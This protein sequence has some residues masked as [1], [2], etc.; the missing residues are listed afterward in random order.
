[1]MP[2]ILLIAFVAAISHVAIVSANS[3][4]AGSCSAG[5]AAIGGTH[6]DF[7]PNSVSMRMGAI[8]TIFEA[9]SIVEINGI[10]LTADTPA[11]FPANTD[12]TWTVT[13]E[14][15][16]YKGIFVRVQA[17][18][19]NA[20]T[21]T[22]VG[23]NLKNEAFCDALTE[24]VIGVSHNSPAPKVTTSGIMN[25][26]GEGSV[27]MDISLVFDNIQ[28]A[29]SAFSSYPLTI[30]AD[31]P[32]A[33]TPM[34]PVPIAPSPVA[35]PTESPVGVPTIQPAPVDV[36][37]PSEPPVDIPV[38]TPIPVY[39]PVD[40]PQPTDECPDDEKGKGMGSKG[41]DGKDKGVKK[42]KEGMMD[43]KEGMMAGKEGMMDGKEGMMDGKESMMDGKK[44]M[45]MGDK[46]A[47]KTEGKKGSKGE[48]GMENTKGNDRRFLK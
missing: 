30:V 24:N 10:R 2:S 13:A 20:F 34:A 23:T 41:K 33:P 3:S 5:V 14:Q 32:T 4:G 22:G 7:G 47:P 38:E 11:S 1:M 36:T 19:D 6:L 9:A 39:L 48:G 12:L 28:F 43:G 35:A 18:D 25:F 26:S 37:V 8:G 42:C 21:H 15:V 27:T 29:I 16:P 17:A 46:T 44:G 40:T 45:M 31:T